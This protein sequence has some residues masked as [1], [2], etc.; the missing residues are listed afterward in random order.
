ME[1]IIKIL[2]NRDELTREEAT[3]IVNDCKEAIKEALEND[4]SLDEGEQLV[5]D[6]LGLEPDY[7]I[8]FL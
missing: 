3:D 8:H 5:Q 4:C 6:Y 1:E 2:M 7:L